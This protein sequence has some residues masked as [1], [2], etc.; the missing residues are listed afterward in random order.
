MANPTFARIVSTEKLTIQDVTGTRKHVA[1]TT[2]QLLGKD[3]TIVG[4]K[5]GTTDEAGKSLILSSVKPSGERIM[6]VLLA[7][8]DRFG[9]GRRALDWAQTAYHWI[10]PL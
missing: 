7:S 4:V 1:Y 9:E 10:Q 3:K 8:P 6:A 2:N 5:T